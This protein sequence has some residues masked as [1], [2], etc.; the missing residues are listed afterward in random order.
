VG[1][2]VGFKKLSIR[3]TQEGLWLIFSMTLAYVKGEK[4]KREKGEEEKYQKL[5]FI[6]L[7]RLL[8]PVS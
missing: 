4:G 1:Q 2:H 5:N 7:F 8:P 6:N 3:Y